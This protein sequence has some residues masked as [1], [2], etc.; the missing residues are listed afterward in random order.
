MGRAVLEDQA[1]A[2]RRHGDAAPRRVHLRTD[3]GW[4]V[5]LQFQTGGTLHTAALTLH[6]G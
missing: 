6:V 2:D 4:R 1:A 5:F 3:T